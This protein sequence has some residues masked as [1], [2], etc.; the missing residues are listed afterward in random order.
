ME[1]MN[2]KFGNVIR[3]AEIKINNKT[4]RI[5]NISVMNEHTALLEHMKANIAADYEKFALGMIKQQLLHPCHSS[6]EHSN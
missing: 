4:T 2:R 6:T 1:E 5:E 3:Q